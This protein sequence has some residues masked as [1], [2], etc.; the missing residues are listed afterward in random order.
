MFE[1]LSGAL[2]SAD[3]DLWLDAYS[4]LSVKAQGELSAYSRFFDKYRDSQASEVTDTL[5]NAYLE[6]QGTEGVKSYG[7]VVDLAVAFYLD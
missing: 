1:Y 6:S 7:M 3:Y 2:Y 4:R 5:N